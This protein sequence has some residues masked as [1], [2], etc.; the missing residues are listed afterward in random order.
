MH[1]RYIDRC[2]AAELDQQY[3]C[4][5][6]VPDHGE[7]AFALAVSADEHGVASA[8]ALPGARR[9]ALVLPL[10]EPVP[11]HAA[12]VGEVQDRGAVAGVHHGVQPGAVHQ[13]AHDD[14]VDL[15]VQDG[16]AL[17]RV[18]RA[19]GLVVPVRLVAVVVR[20]L[21]A[22]AREVEHQGVAVAAALHQPVHRHPDVLLRGQPERVPLVVCRQAGSERC[23]QTG[24]SVDRSAI[25]I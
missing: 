4:M 17:E 14:L 5:Y 10:P 15:V 7:V 19:D 6:H 25:Y 1:V 13:R 20:H 21:R 8:G 18:Q 23:H 16:P 12:L 22:D 3:V 24:Y 2:K 9:R 11:G